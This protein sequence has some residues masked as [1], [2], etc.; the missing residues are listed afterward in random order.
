MTSGRRER[1][2]QAMRERAAEAARHLQA[3]QDAGYG[4]LSEDDLL[5]A[6]IIL[7]QARLRPGSWVIRFGTWAGYSHAMVYVG[8]GEII[9]AE[10]PDQPNGNA[11]KLEP[12]DYALQG[13]SRASVYRHLRALNQNQRDLVVQILE[14]VYEQAPAYGNDALRQPYIIILDSFS[15][16]WG[17]SVRPFD[18][19][20]FHCSELVA[21]AYQQA[22]MPIIHPRIGEPHPNPESYSPGSLQ[23]AVASLQRVGLLRGHPSQTRMAPEERR[24]ARHGHGGR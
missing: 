3:E 24:A 15:Q 6:D 8:N 11:I 18:E 4:A 10:P 20:A 2:V 12:L 19:S 23:R 13:A 9:H 16:N 14:R 17:E 7:T 5:V 21:Y 22:G 1:R